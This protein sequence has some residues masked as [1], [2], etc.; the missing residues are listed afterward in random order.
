MIFGSARPPDYMQLIAR[1]YCP[2]DR[3]SRNENRCPPP[4]SSISN[5]EIVPFPKHDAIFPLEY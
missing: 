2:L 5:T 4:S 1:D 3:V